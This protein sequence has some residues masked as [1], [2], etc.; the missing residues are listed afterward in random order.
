[1]Q[2]DSDTTP[3]PTDD[4]LGITVDDASGDVYIATAAG[5][6]GYAGDAQ[7]PSA[8]SDALR[9]SPNPFRPH[10]NADL[11]ISGLNAPASRIRVLTVDGR[12][13]YEDDSVFGGSF[14]WDGRDARTGEPVPS[15]VYLIAADGTDGEPTIYGKLAVLH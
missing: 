3:L 12:V 9:V 15:G 1:M 13:V 10:E 11:L 14:R 2:L 4:L 6:Y 7:A 5:L 8:S